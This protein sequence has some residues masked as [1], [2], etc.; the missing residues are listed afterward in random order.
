MNPEYDALFEKMK[1]MENS[2]ERQK[3]ID[4]MVEIAR[5]DAPWIWG[6]HPKDYSLRHSWLANDKPNNMARNNIKYLK[7]D[8]AKRE[9]L[10]REWNRPVVWPV[11]LIIGLL[12]LSAVPALMSYR[13]RERMAARPAPPGAPAA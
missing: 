3:I 1:N 11:L 4:R 8:V 9:A 13:R 7:L 2:P 6:I 5:R 12:V 10:R